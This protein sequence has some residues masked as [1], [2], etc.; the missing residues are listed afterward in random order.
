VRLGRRKAKLKEHA[1]CTS[2]NALAT[3]IRSGS[4]SA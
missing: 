2:Q 1:M 4:M 3:I